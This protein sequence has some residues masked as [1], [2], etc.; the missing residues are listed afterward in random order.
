MSRLGGAGTTEWTPP[1]PL[2]VWCRRSG[3]TGHCLQIFLFTA[4]RNSLATGGRR[5]AGGLAET[6]YHTHTSRLPA[7]PQTRG[8]QRGSYGTYVLARPL[9]HVSGG[10][11]YAAPDLPGLSPRARGRLQSGSRCCPFTG[12]AQFICIAATGGESL[13]GSPRLGR[14]QAQS[15]YCVG[16]SVRRSR[17]PHPT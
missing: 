10:G 11:A 5:A 8:Q 7:T 12:S 15:M 3:P 6:H 2:G 4:P 16:A 9:R 13:C 1:P 17:P 14:E